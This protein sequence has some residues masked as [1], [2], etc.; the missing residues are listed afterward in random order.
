MFFLIEEMVK[1]RDVFIYIKFSSFRSSKEDTKTQSRQAFISNVLSAP[2]WN[3][4]KKPCKTE[5]WHQTAP[6][7]ADE[8]WSFIDSRRR[9]SGEKLLRDSSKPG[10]LSSPVFSSYPGPWLLSTELLGMRTQETIAL[11]V[12]QGQRPPLPG[13]T[14]PSSWNTHMLMTL[15]IRGLLPLHSTFLSRL[16]SPA[17]G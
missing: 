8:A 9:D 7:E 1:E 2:C 6:Q 16:P 17:H 12:P 5:V 11:S 10:T 13:S 3:D 14:H 15:Y 4:C